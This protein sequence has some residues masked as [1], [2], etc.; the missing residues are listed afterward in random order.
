MPMF[1]DP[2]ILYISP[3][4]FP[5]YQSDCLLHGLKSLLGNNVLDAFPAWYLYEPTEQ[6]R[7]QFKSLYGKGFTLYGL[8]KAR[9]AVDRTDIVRK[10]R[11]NYFDL[12]IYGSIH[13]C[14]KYLFDVLDHYA[15]SRV[16]FVDGE[17]ST[18]LYRMV[19]GRGRYFKRE[20]L[21]HWVPSAGALKLLPIGFGIPKEKIVSAI[22]RKH[23]VIAHID[24][25]D[26][27][28]YIYEN[29]AHYYKGYQDS[30]FG[31]TI[32]KAGWDCMRHY[33]ILANGC[34][35]IF[36]DLP[37]FPA[38]VM[39]HYPKHQML[40]AYEYLT[41]EKKSS[42]IVPNDEYLKHLTAAMCT[43]RKQCTTEAIAR[44][45]LDQF[46]DVG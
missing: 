11:S 19:V 45:L 26:K 7:P 41:Q 28:T 16:C 38:S 20:L 8:L 18:D 31:I 1:R 17:D 36:L 40:W 4:D 35:P 9:E 5:D 24:P 29:E 25:R 32:K 2:R 6:N 22:P 37:Q 43:L 30:C 44:Y 21:E 42:E 13:R 39:T 12:V 15:P 27:R 10:I 46:G 23:R 14:Q 34:L 33:E 3:G